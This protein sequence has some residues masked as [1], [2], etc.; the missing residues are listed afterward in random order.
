MFDL[1]K[2]SS[3]LHFDTLWIPSPFWAA[4]R[5]GTMSCHKK[6]FQLDYKLLTSEDY[7][8]INALFR[9]KIYVMF[10]QARHVESSFLESIKLKGN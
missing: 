9:Q 1:L 2:M 10:S 5:K 3:R 6:S 4:M 7:C 8:Y